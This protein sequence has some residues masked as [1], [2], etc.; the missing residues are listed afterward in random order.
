MEHGKRGER[1]RRIVAR[2]SGRV[3][4]AQLLELGF[5]LEMVYSWRRRGLLLDVL[6]RVYAIGHLAP[7]READLWAAVL[8]AGPDAA[9]S[10]G[11]AAH[12]LGLIK[13]APGS[14]EV[15]TP[16]VKVRSVG[17]IR[18]YGW[19][20]RGR[21]M[22]RGVP[23]TMIPQTVLDLAAGGNLRLVRRA[24]AQ[25]DFRKQLD[26]AAIEAVCGH[27]RPG[28]KL[29]RRALAVHQPRLAH[30]NEELEARFFEWCERWRVPLP[31]FNVRVH[32]QLVDAYWPEH[33][34][35]VEM[36]GDANHSSPAQRRGDRKKEL[37]LRAHGLTVL[38]YD[39]AL[40]HD[41]PGA[42]HADL[43]AQLAAREPAATG[44]GVAAAHAATA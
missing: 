27:G 24:L 13:Y 8:Y 3:T 12:W 30:T 36:D 43:I 38:R 44:R 20:E 31:R 28:S 29:L 40:L 21:V 4:R 23:V 33:G 11:T 1:L 5:T 34:L 22:H 41:L 25:L 14:I 42:M 39:W 10:H 15:S 32:G 35:V 17:G 37:I 16:R 26:V 18:V 9:L 2:Q 7:S 19:R 6:P